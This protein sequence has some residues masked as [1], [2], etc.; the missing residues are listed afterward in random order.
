MKQHIR[1]SGNEMATTKTWYIMFLQNIITAQLMQY[2]VLSLSINRLS[3]GKLNARSIF[4]KIDI[5]TQSYP[6][7]YISMKFLL[8]QT[9]KRS[10][11]SNNEG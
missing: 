2:M 5:Y 4:T 1:I 11:L 3:E 9:V 8:A 6:L 10:R 7:L